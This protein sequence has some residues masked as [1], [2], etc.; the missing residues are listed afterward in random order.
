[1]LDI[2][3]IESMKIDESVIVPFGAL[4]RHMHQP[5]AEK[6]PVKL[7]LRLTAVVQSVDTAQA[8]YTHTFP[9]AC[10]GQQ[11]YTYALQPV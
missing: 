11:I 4:F 9:G 5:Q 8:R 1:M 2:V 3:P 6:G 7:D 10:E